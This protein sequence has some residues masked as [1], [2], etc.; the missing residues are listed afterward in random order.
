MNSKIDKSRIDELNSK[1]LGFDVESLRRSGKDYDFDDIYLVMKEYIETVRKILKDETYLSLFAESKI[2]QFADRVKTM[3]NTLVKIRDFN[4]ASDNPKN[5]Q[6]SLITSFGN[7]YENFKKDY[8]IPFKVYELEKDVNRIGITEKKDELN[9]LIEQVKILKT[10]LEEKAVEASVSN[11]AKVFEKEAN[12]HNYASWIWLGFAIA[13]SGVTLCVIWAYFDYHPLYSNQLSYIVTKITVLLLLFFLVTF[14]FKQFSVNR[15]L[16]T[17]N[18]HRE[19]TLNSYKLFIEGLGESEM[20]VRN[21][22][23][24]QVAKAIYEQGKSGYINEKGSDMET[25][26]VIELIRTLPKSEK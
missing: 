13:L 7:E 14:L 17:L 25:P 19:N 4:P 9:G 23:M 5:V 8:I 22:I 2:N 21:A 18:K 3:V 12:K 11:Y 15:H 16:Y 20:D 26:S 10:E 24:M 1:L 6:N